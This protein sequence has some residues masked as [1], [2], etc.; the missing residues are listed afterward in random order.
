MKFKSIRFKASILYT[1]ILCVILVVFSSMLFTV[2]RYVLYRDLNEKLKI[3][4][5][6]IANILEA[7]QEVKEI[8]MHPFTLM[9]RFFSGEPLEDK[10]RMIIDEL[11]RSEA[12]TLNLKNDYINILNIRGQSVFI[13]ENLDKEI[14]LLFRNKL[15]PS[16]QGEIFK[17]IKDKKHCLRAINLPV[18]NQNQFSFIIQLG[19]PLDSV[20]T[21]LDK[22]LFFIIMAVLLILGLTSFL[23]SFFA[24]SILRPVI[25]VSK[26][27]DSISYKDLHLR[28][29]ETEMDDEMT[30]LV[31]SFNDMIG[32]LEKSFEHISDFSSHVAHELKT[33]LAIIRGELELAL[34]E[35]RDVQ[36]YKRVINVS[37]QE[38]DRLIKI[39]KDLLLLAKLDYKPDIFNFENM[40][41][42]ELLK[43]IYEH[44]KILTMRK[45]IKINLQLPAQE[46]VINGD[47]IHL[48]RLFFNLI[49]NA[50]KFTPPAGS[51]TISLAV[52]DKKAHVAISDT[53]EGI[54]QENLSKIFD[55]FFRVRKD[56]PDV[57][58]GSGLGLTIAQSI[59]KAHRGEIVV[60]SQLSQGS[61]FT[62]ILPL[63]LPLNIQ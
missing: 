1:S 9:N 56:S 51:I 32:R 26:T 50:V 61:T 43:D 22:L 37:L 23:G 55:K 21:L 44:S 17:D 27:A 58:S 48:R 19:T 13:S 60:Q 31:N 33:P 62:V 10:E 28:I 18:L 11:W 42:S 41:L 16:V 40:S 36:E 5:N 57:E 8:Q 30:Y 63:V 46:A 25:N 54:A 47:K 29:S 2:V 38:I 35:A 7:Y 59:A 4:A 49:N 3:K 6:E 24:K 45:K 39:V 52:P 20:L 14:A 34:S 15:P 12:R 53:G